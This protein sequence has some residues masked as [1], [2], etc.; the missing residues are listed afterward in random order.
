M[1]AIAGP[2]SRAPSKPVPPGA[3]LSRPARKAKNPRAQ[4]LEALCPAVP[5]A[6]RWDRGTDARC[7]GAPDFAI[8]RASKRA[9]TPV[10][11]KDKRAFTPVFGKDKRAFTPVFG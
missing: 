2:I 8:A 7:P 11:G 4:I 9:F 3:P 10:F 6:W 1:H 5:R